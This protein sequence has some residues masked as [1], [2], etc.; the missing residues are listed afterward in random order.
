MQLQFYKYQ[1]TGNDFVMIDNRQLFF[2]KDDIKLIEKLCDRRF[3]IGA[4]GLILLE[5][6]AE[7][8]FKMVYYNSDGNQSSMC[9][10]GG[11]CIVAFAKQLGLIKNQTT[12]MAIDGLHH[13]I[14]DEKQIVSLQMK[15]V[16]EV[17]I[18]SDYIFLNTGSPH[19]VALVDDLKNFDVK[20][21]GAKIRYSNLYGKEGSN[22]NFVYQISDNHFAV[23]TYERGVE[24]ETFSCGTGVTA[25]AIAMNAISKTNSNEIDLDV[26]GGKLKVSFSKE[27]SSF[28]NVHLIGP[29]TFVFEGFIEI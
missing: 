23:R 10:N 22:V 27:N 6:D 7:T 19:H 18:E 13:A 9:G 3:G 5:N 26:E 17:K 1:G 8:D 12:F 29:A 25:V 16:N 21:S 15:D 4:D 28:K 24:D 2:P 14:I 11:R 20:N